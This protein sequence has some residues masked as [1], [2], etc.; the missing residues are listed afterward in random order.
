[1][2]LAKETLW[3]QFG[4]LALM[5]FHHCGGEDRAILGSLTSWFSKICELQIHREIPSQKFK[6]R[7]ITSPDIDL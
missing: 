7:K 3:L 6:R 4:S 2:V 1:M 5:S